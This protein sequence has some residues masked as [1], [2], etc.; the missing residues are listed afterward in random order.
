ML[1][2][3]GE[4]CGHLYP[5]GTVREHTGHHIAGSLSVMV[6]SYQT[7]LCMGKHKYVIYGESGQF[8]LSHA[9]EILLKSIFQGNLNVTNVG[10]VV[11][12][13]LGPH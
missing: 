8:S 7:I 11:F 4:Y 3:R 1:G 5:L 2:T 6:L 12:R 10:L 13:L 9:K